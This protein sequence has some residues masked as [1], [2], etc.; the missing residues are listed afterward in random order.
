MFKK[1]VSFLNFPVDGACTQNEVSIS[2]IL[3]HSPIN[4]PI[5]AFK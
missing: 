1:G 5:H 3:S 2:F 4:V